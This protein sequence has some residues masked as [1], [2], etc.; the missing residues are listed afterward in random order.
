VVKSLL[1]SRIWLVATVSFTVAAVGSLL[2][3]S[4]I[5]AWRWIV[6]AIG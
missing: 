4:I 2:G 1:M 5:R 6:R 3:A